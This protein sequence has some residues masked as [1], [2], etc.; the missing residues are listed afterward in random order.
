P[1][2][3]SS[4][5]SPTRRSSDLGWHGYA[6]AGQPL[7]NRYRR[8]LGRMLEVTRAVRLPD[9]R[10]PVFGDQDSGRVLPAGFARPPTQDHLLDLGAAL[11]GGPRALEDPPHEEVAWTAGLGAWN[12]LARRPV[13]SRP[14]RTAF[15]DGGIYVM[16]PGCATPV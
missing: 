7:S 3:P 2:H 8:R 14:I 9:G 12:E 15:P 11:L 13:E 4:L 10:T 16:D 6:L 5:R 1:L